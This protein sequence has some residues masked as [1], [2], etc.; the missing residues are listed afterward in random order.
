MVAVIVL[1]V[2]DSSCGL[3]RGSWYGFLYGWYDSEF[4]QKLIDVFPVL[5]VI[6]V[7]CHDKG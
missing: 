4:G 2:D 6:S 1:L 5:T 3:C 7:H